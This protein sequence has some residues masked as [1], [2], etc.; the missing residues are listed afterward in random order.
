LRDRA[1]KLLANDDATEA[2]FIALSNEIKGPTSGRQEQPRTVLT[3]W[4]DITNVVGMK[5]SD[6]RALKSLNQRFGGPIVNSGPGTRPMVYRE[7]LLDWWDTLAVKQQDLMNQREGRRLSAEA[8]HD[9]GR[10]GRV[11]PEIGG[12]VKKRRK[13]RKT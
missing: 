9:Y 5:Y 10:S 13:D 1:R 8:Q 11:A 12:N 3:S 7:D 4:H 2:D 6:R